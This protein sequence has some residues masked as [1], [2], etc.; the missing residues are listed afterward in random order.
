[1]SNLLDLAREGG[2]VMA[3]MLGLSVVTIA[4]GL[5]RAWF[6]YRLLSKEDKV[7]RD[8]LDAAQN[9]GRVTGGT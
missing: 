2:P 5:E 7:V 3:P 6:W 8:V 1:M 4:C 9:V